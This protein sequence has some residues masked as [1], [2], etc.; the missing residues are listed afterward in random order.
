[1]RIVPNSAKRKLV[2]MFTTST[3][4]GRAMFARILIAAF[5][6]M[7]AFGA[8]SRAQDRA[9]GEIFKDCD[10]CPQM[11][12][13]PSGRFT[14][15]SPDSEPKR[16]DDEGPQHSVNIGRF[17]V[18]KYEV[19]FAE[20]DACAADGYCRAIARGGHWMNG[21]QD[22]GRERRPVITVSWDDIHGTSGDGKRGFLAWLQA[23]T[24]HVYRLLTESEWEYAARAG[25]DGPFHF[26]D[27]ITTD[28]ANLNGKY[29]YNGSSKG[30][31]RGKTVAV[32]SF[33]ANAFGLHDML[34]NAWEWTEDC[35]HDNYKNAPSD[36]SAWMDANGGDC[37]SAVLRGG[38]WNGS[39][40]YLRSANRD[41]VQRVNRNYS[42]GFRVAR[43]FGSQL[44]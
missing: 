19:T 11:V 40:Q 32:G 3:G 34:G 39:P 37:S 20:W 21:D 17:A 10:I 28:Q 22:W 1:M 25:S 6:I 27:R 26:G 9:D 44:N 24:G 41:G 15:G 29:T 13:I 30:E 43:T 7:L 38:S 5:G 8:A 36:S 42:I 2:E 23:K 4:A 14:M 16:Y 33:P 31:S 12:V 18:G 35:W